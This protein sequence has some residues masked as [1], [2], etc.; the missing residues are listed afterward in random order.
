MCLTRPTLKPFMAE[1]PTGLATQWKTVAN[2]EKT[3]VLASACDVVA[4]PATFLLV[5]VIAERFCDLRPLGSYVPEYNNMAF[6]KWS[7]RLLKPY[8]TIFEDA[9]DYGEKKLHV[10]QR[11]TSLSGN[12]NN[13]L[14]DD[15]DFGGVRFV[16]KLFGTTVG[17]M[18]A[19]LTRVGRREDRTRL[20]ESLAWPIPLY[21]VDDF[22]LLSAAR[23][24]APFLACHRNGL[25][26]APVDLE[27]ALK[28][29]W[30]RLLLPFTTSTSTP[31]TVTRSTPLS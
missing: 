27:G 25:A 20:R 15:D 22:A 8:D 11:D 19:S 24:F 5:G 3:Y 30:Q 16:R 31:S 9:F 21:A 12:N 10:L 2:G 18:C 29:F 14:A 6:P 13:L 26:I 1:A 23:E 17:F 7:F 28:G 4:T